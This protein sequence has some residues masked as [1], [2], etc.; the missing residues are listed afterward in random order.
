M[1]N[2]PTNT[3]GGTT[4][5]FSNTPQAVDDKFFATEDVIYIFD[6]M[7]N[8]LGGNAKTL[9]SVDDGTNSTGSTLPGSDLLS[10]DTAR[11]ESTSTDKSFGGA[12]IWIT[13]DGKVGYDASAFNFLG[14]GQTFTDHFTYAIRLGNGTLSWATV[15]VTL[16]GTNDGPTIAASTQTGLVTE[17]STPTSTGGHFA[18]ADVDLT[19]THTVTVTPASNGYLGTLTANVSNDTTGDGTGQVD[20][21]FSVDNAAIQYLGA[22]DTLTQTYTVQVSDGHGGMANQTVTVTIHGT[23]DGPTIAATT[24]AGSVTEDSTPTS[25]GGH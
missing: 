1:G 24:Q 21:S 6:V 17:D 19:D 8:D 5:S 11:A 2:T 3:G 7:A 16:T 14:A 25:T 23:N 15:Y 10:Q 9:W 22:N 4:T 12:R 20:W 13:S 18:F